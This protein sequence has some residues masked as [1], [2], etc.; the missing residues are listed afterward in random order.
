VTVDGLFTSAGGGDRNAPQTGVFGNDSWRRLVS[1]FVRN[2]SERQV[3]GWRELWK[4]AGADESGY[5]FACLP[6]P[7][8]KKPSAG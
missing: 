4:C 2:V 7:P 5:Y 6:R 8:V 1:T 3:G